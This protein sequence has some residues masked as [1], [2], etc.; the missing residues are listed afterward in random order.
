MEPLNNA[1]AK[2]TNALEQAP[3]KSMPLEIS[4]QRLS[5]AIQQPTVLLAKAENVLDVLL[6]I[7]HKLGIRA[8]ALPTQEATKVLIKHVK[9][10]YSGHTC[11]EIALA[12]DMAITGKL[13][14]DAKEIPCYENFSCL[15][16]SRIMNAYRRWA[17]QEY[18]ALERNEP[19]P[20]LVREIVDDEGM[21]DWLNQVIIYSQDPAY[22]V[23]WYPEILYT[24]LESKGRIRAGLAEEM[25]YL[26]LAVERRQAWLKFQVD[27]WPSTTNRQNLANLLQMKKEGYF[28]GAEIPALQ[29]LAKKIALMDVILKLQG[30]E[31]Q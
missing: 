30:N 25:D 23:E 20:V 26:V 10:E 14:L 12:F 18:K 8:A 13:D 3:P 11:Q 24:W 2:V 4:A 9:S 5:M 7:M 17:A 21:Q 29:S 31:N 27:Q 16:F 1:L 15:Y 19:P 28:T 22:T 6:K